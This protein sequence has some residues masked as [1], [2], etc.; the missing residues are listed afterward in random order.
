ME[1]DDS[2]LVA[3]VDGELDAEAA[4]SVEAALAQDAEARRKVRDLSRSAG[5]LRG[6]FGAVL[7]DPVPENLIDKIMR[8]P[9]SDAPQR[10][11]A[12][13]WTLAASIAFLL[14]GGAIGYMAATVGPEPLS[15]EARVGWL[16]TYIAQYHRIYAGEK[17]HL[18][19]V[20]ADQTPHI[21]AWL[22]KRLGRQLKVPDLSAEALEFKGARLLVFDDKPVVQLMYLPRDG[23]PIAI[24]ITRSDGEDSSAKLDRRDDLNLLHWRSAGYVYV[25][26]GWVGEARL[27][28][29]GAIAGRQLHGAEVSG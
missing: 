1:L 17:R 12:L 28:D 2:I 18:V 4:R 10:R 20:G 26:V 19:E 27:R 3:Y 8:Y 13:K 7:H 6:A 15:A 24:C 21:E 23:R 11:T 9:V 5:L 22:G 25:V 29:V 16:I 14:G